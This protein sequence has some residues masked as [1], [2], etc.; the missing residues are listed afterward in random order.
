MCKVV[1]TPDAGM[2]PPAPGL[3]WAVVAEPF[4]GIPVEEHVFAGAA[5]VPAAIEPQTPQRFHASEDVKMLAHNGLHAVLSCIGHLKGAKHFDELR[6]DTEMMELGR[7]LLVEEA[8]RALLRKHAGALGRNEF[9]NYCDSILR[10]VTCPVLH[11]P[12]ARGVRGTMRKLQPWERLVYSV[13]TVA[14]QGGEPRAFAAGLAAAATI[15]VSSGE[16][17]LGFEAV[18]TD[19]CGFDPSADA[20]LIE[21]IQAERKALPSPQPPGPIA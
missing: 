9:A 4:F 12:I 19:H 6:G 5:C 18:L 11:D 1:S 15:A 3:D 2:A 13:R 7:R 14:E 8:A 10:R 21:L 17:D 16:T 20:P